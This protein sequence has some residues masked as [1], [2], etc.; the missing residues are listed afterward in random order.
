[1]KAC[2]FI[3]AEP[4]WAKSTFDLFAHLTKGRSNAHARYSS[5]R[6]VTGCRMCEDETLDRECEIPAYERTH[7]VTMVDSKAISRPSRSSPQS[8][9]ELLLFCLSHQIQNAFKAG[10][11][12]NKMLHYY[13]E[14]DFD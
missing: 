9:R 2:T 6:W 11:H 13:H 12:E 8:Q 5:G 1:M 10:A 7:P 3:P 14:R 4:K